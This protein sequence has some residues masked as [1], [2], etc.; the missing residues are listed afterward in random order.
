MPLH[1]LRLPLALVL[2]ASVAAPAFAQAMLPACVPGDGRTPIGEWSPTIDAK[3]NLS[4]APP[5]ADGLI[6]HIDIGVDDLVASCAGKPEDEL[7][8]FSVPN[9]PD[10][11]LAGGLSVNIRGNVQFANGTCH[12]TGYYMN[13]PV[14]GMHQGWLQTYFGPVDKAMVMTSDR[15]CQ[16]SGPR[17][18]Q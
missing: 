4:E 8:S 5:E 17:A 10:D 18:V 14:E 3:G 7:Y 6:V 2:V 1:H 11:P 12:F 15:F 16:P 9:D 13:E